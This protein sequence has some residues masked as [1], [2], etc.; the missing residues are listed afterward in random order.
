MR[1]LMVLIAAV[2]MSW[3]PG[4]Q[5]KGGPEDPES[6][7][8]LPDK[9]DVET[10]AADVPPEIARFQ[11]AWIGTWA[12]EIRHILVVERVQ[13]LGN[14][15]IVFAIGDSAMYG[16]SREWWRTQAAIT[17]GVLT[18][19]GFRTI[20]YAFDGADRLFM[21]S[22]LKSGRTTSG[23]LVRREVG[24]LK[25]HVKPDE[26][27][28]P[29]Q[30]VAVPHLTKRTAD[31]SRPILLEATFYAAAGA[32]PA[33]L[34]IVNHGSDVGRDLLRSFSYSTVAHWLRDKGFA[35]LVLM[36][37]GRGKSEGVYGE[38]DYGRDHEGTITDCSKGI[39]EGIE[40]LESAIAYGRGLPGIRPG[41]VLLVG[42][43]RGGFLSVYYAGLKPAEVLGVVSF[44]GG[45]VPIEP[46]VAPYFTRAGRGT[47]SKVPELWL[48]ADNDN[49]YNEALIRDSYQ[50]FETA[51]GRARFELLH[52]VPGDGH[53][54]RFYPDRWRQIADQFLA[55]LSASQV[56]AQNH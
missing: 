22:T 37:R 15:N 36:R 25:G 29:G 54:L 55:T 38:G 56:R 4:V 32:N 17:D 46:L 41:P 16:F 5:A 52:G 28:W 13:P 2:L 24:R 11:G 3:M 51:G 14:A 21:T 23:T 48:Y 31:G 7:V 53:L 45:W 30:R 49:Q 47:G 19:T 9:L 8:P 33:P 1:K 20:R 50:A 42:Q 44:A 34:A 6:I 26:W 35:V 12:D 40:D 39:G 18:I 27:P 43:S 10:P